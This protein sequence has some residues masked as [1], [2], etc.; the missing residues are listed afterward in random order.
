MGLLIPAVQKVREAANRIRCQNNLKQLGLALHQYHDRNGQFPLGS[1]NH[2]PLPYQAPRLTYMYRLYPYLEQESVF[3]R[4]NPEAR[5]GSFF[6][7]YGGYIPWCSSPS[8]SIGSDP[9]TGVVLRVLLCPSD[10]LGSEQSVAYNNDKLVGIW[11]HSNYLALFGDK[12]YGAGFPGARPQNQ[13][14]AFGWNYGAR[15]DEIRDGTSNSLL[16]SEYLTGLPQSEAQEDYRGVHWIDAP[17][18]SQIYTQSAPNNSN[19]DLFYGWRCYDRA[20]LNLPCADSTWDESTA[21]ARSRHLGGVNVLLADGSVR[22]V[23]QTIDLH[24]WQ[25]LGT[26]DGGEVPADY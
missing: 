14:A 20:D 22:F 8:N 4:F 7:D 17:G 6:L 9:P 24:I 2:A 13:R 26:I 15:I 1:Q 12:N 5:D 10:G 11:S 21:A 23:S 18:Y 16:M 19:P 3:R 25:A